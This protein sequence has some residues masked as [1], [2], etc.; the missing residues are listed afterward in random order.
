ML[1]LAVT[2]LALALGGCEHCEDPAEPLIEVVVDVEVAPADNDYLHIEMLNAGNDHV[3]IYSVPASVAGPRVT[4]LLGSCDGFPQRSGAFTIRSWLSTE[5]YDAVEPAPTDPQGMAT[6]E[7][8]CD[9]G[10]Y[11]A[12]DVQVA[13]RAP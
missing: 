5:A 3:D 13:V 4:H 7:V 11:A 9:V 12:N 6:V 2:I 1:R 8:T 10:C